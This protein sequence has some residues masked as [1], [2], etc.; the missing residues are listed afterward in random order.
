[1]DHL[2]MFLGRFFKRLGRF[3]KGMMRFFKG[4]ARFFTRPFKRA[5]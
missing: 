2:D 1:M 5:S 4:M 3:F